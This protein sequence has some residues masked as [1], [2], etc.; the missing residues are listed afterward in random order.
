M[1]FSDLSV[2]LSGQRE[3]AR[4]RARRLQQVLLFF[5]IFFSVS[6]LLKNQQ[7]LTYRL[8]GLG[9]RLGPDLPETDRCDLES[10]QKTSS[11]LCAEKINTIG[12]P[13]FNFS[14]V[15]FTSSVSERKCV[16]HQDKLTV[17]C[18]QS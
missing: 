2:C 7:H 5:R 6:S 10:H 8:Y 13:S 3:R 4:L 17:L 1:R 15:Q 18:V 14:K 16:E 12:T 9:G 11:L